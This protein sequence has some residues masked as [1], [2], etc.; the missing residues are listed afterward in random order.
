M[1]NALGTVPN[2]K[3]GR[4]CQTGLTVSNSV[5]FSNSELEHLNVFDVTELYWRDCLLNNLVVERL[6]QRGY[7]AGV[8]LGIVLQLSRAA[9]AV[10]NINYYYQFP[11]FCY[12][13]PYLLV[14]LMISDTVIALNTEHLYRKVLVLFWFKTFSADTLPLIICKVTSNCMIVGLIFTDHSLDY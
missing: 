5:F 9:L 6:P 11:F 8:R 13:T 14:D 12:A 7:S 4:G 3:G 1:I 10:E 2:K